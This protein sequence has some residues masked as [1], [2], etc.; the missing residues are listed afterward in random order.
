MTSSP[1]A[2]SQPSPLRRAFAWAVARASNLYWVDRRLARSAQLYG[3]H[4]G[5]VLS[6]YGFRTVINLRGENPKAKWYRDESAA[7]AAAGVRY[8]DLPINSRRLPKR[9]QLLAMLDAFGDMQAPAL[10]KCSGGADRTGLAAFLYVLDRDGPAGFPAARRHLNALPY[11]HLP[12]LH[13]RWM[14]RF[15]DYWQE[16]GGPDMPVRRWVEEVYDG[17]DF[18]AWLNA[19]GLRDGYRGT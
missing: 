18:A 17:E 8:V 2:P 19:R 12:K 5:L 11:L 15:L 4:V 10:V 7:C 6:T 9:A 14:R 16:T 1:V 3:A 13:Q